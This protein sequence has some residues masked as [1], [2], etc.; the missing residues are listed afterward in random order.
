VLPPAVMAELARV[1][2]KIAP[3]STEEARAMV[4]KVRRG[5]SGVVRAVWA[6]QAAG[7]SGPAQGRT[8][9]RAPLLSRHGGDCS[10]TVD[11]F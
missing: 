8:P 10:V 9:W 2:D 4:E 11:P 6:V 1:Q 3:F 5:Q 7:R